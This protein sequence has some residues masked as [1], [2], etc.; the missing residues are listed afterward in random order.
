MCQPCYISYLR[1]KVRHLNTRYDDA[2]QQRDD[3]IQQRDEV[4]IEFCAASEE[5]WELSDSL[6][7]AQVKIERLE[8]LLNN[9]K[10]RRGR[11]KQAKKWNKFLF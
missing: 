3:A 8:R 6:T 7:Q 1:A 10:R 4:H 2:I 11:Q 9:R 5:R